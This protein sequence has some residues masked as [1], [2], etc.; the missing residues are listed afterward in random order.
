MNS[1]SLF[2]QLVA[3]FTSVFTL[4]IAYALPLSLFGLVATSS[5]LLS[6][7]LP[8]FLFFWILSVP[9]DVVWLIYRADQARLIVI[10]LMGANMIFKIASAGQ[11]ARILQSQ[12]ALPEVGGGGFGGIG[13]NQGWLGAENG[14]AGTGAF[15][16][17]G[18]WSG[19]THQESGH[20]HGKEKKVADEC[21]L[22]C[23]SLYAILR[24]AP[25]SD[26]N[27]AAPDYASTGGYRSVYD[28]DQPELESDAP[29]VRVDHLTHTLASPAAPKGAKRGDYSAIQ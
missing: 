7:L 14:T 22:L 27:Q 18:S 16:L 24:P 10:T 19:Q 9:L 13:S 26:V 23:R 5:T 1:S 29:Q 21:M 17:P 4:H 28:G 2:L 25:Y 12:G 8:H 11:A 3:L 15:G 20:L 6:T